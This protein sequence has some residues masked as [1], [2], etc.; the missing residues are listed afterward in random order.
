MT[1]EI[2][3]FETRFKK[4]LMSNASVELTPQRENARGSSTRR[5]LSKASF[6]KRHVV[7]VS[8]SD[9]DG[10][11]NRTIDAAVSVQL[12]RVVSL[13]RTHPSIFLAR[14]ARLR[15][16]AW[17]SSV[18]NRDADLLSDWRIQR[19]SSSEPAAKYRP[20]VGCSIVRFAAGDHSYNGVIKIVLQRFQFDVEEGRQ[21]EQRRRRPI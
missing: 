9:V 14:A 17:S 16:I 4:K 18:L 15:S 5:R 20:Q 7:L 8:G 21:R 2:C 6:D 10:R 12:Q 1:S 3:I 13:R 19:A 11:R